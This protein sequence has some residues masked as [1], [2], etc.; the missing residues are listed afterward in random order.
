MSDQLPGKG[1]WENV[2]GTDLIVA[3]ASFSSVGSMGISP[4][5]TVA[6]GIVGKDDSKVPLDP[7]AKQ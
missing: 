4:K 2:G 5:D 7:A 6:A 3:T 1:T